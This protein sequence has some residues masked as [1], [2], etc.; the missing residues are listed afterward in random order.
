MVHDV[1]EAENKLAVVMVIVAPAIPDA[2][3][4]VI[5]AGAVTVNTADAK[6][7]VGVPVSEIG[8]KMEGVEIE[9][10]T[11]AVNAPPEA[12]HDNWL[13]YP[14]KGGVV[15]IVHPVSDVENPNPSA[16]TVMPGGPTPGVN[17][18]VGTEVTVKLAVVASAGKTSGVAVIV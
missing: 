1:S 12:E 17:V 5:A 10:L 2:E 11:E 3:E 16:V 14:A 9:T 4:S 6:S 13:M 18:M 15:A 7:F 8:I